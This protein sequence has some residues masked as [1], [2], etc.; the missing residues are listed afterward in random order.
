[1]DADHDGI[2]SAIASSLDGVEER[3]LAHGSDLV[4]PYASMVL[5]LER[6]EARDV[7]E[8]I[9][10]RV[11]LGTARAAPAGAFSAFVK[12]ALALLKR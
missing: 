12:R 4:H 2:G 10:L 5:G 8:E 7:T 1:M 11:R 9:A 3:R 6:Y